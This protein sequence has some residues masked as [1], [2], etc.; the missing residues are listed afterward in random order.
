M[1][2]EDNNNR[3]E[4]TGKK[5][6]SKILDKS[7]LGSPFGDNKERVFF[8]NKKNNCKSDIRDILP[9][10]IFKITATMVTNFSA[11]KLEKIFK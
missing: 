9:P 8:C 7:A 3:E 11:F 6:C 2:S 10:R 1:S 4:I 5:Y